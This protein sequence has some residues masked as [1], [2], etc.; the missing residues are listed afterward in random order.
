MELNLFGGLVECYSRNEME[1]MRCDEVIL[2][3]CIKGKIGH[4]VDIDASLAAISQGL[5]FR[6]RLSNNLHESNVL[7]AVLGIPFSLPQVSMSLDDVEEDHL[8][9]WKRLGVRI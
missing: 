6:L 3:P 1:Y 7:P 8:Q 2:Y 9:I 4:I 5:S